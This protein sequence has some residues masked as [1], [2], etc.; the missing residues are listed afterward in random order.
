[1]N[2]KINPFNQDTKNQSYSERLLNKQTAK[3]KEILDVQAPYRWNLQRLNLGFTLDIGCGIGRNLMNLKGNGIGIDHNFHSVEVCRARG[4]TA[5][6]P[7][8]FQQSSFDEPEKFDSIL[9]AHVAEHM[10]YLEVISLLNDY[11]Y[12]LKNHG[13]LVIITPQEAGFKSDATHVEFM[14]FAKLKAIARE[15]DSKII[16]QYSFPFPRMVGKLFKYNEFVSLSQK[17]K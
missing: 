6:T 1:M 14:N 4:F 16:Q 13:K 3:W 9:L 2:R 15:L 12:L 8:E 17:E 11:V 5:F 7:E 10:S